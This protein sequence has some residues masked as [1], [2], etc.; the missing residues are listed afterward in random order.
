MHETLKKITVG[1]ADYENKT[2]QMDIGRC[3]WVAGVGLYGFCKAHKRT[4]DGEILKFLSN[5]V[6]INIDEA[7]KM[8]KINTAVLMYTVLYVYRQNGNERYLALCKKIADYFLYEAPKTRE[9]ALEH[10]VI[11]DAK[12]S[13]QIW[14]DTLFMAVIFLAEMGEY[15][16]K[17]A[18]FAAKQLCIHLESLY[19]NNTDL[20]FHAWN[21]I[22]KN[23][24]SG[25]RWGRANA[26]IIYSATEI[27]GILGDFEG[28]EVVKSYVKK[29]AA[30]LKELQTQNGAFRTVLNEESYEEASATAGVI[31]GI[32]QAVQLGIIE[33]EY[34]CVFDK[35]MEYLMSVIAENGEVNEVS[36]GTPV[37]KSSE[38]YK[39]IICVPTLY[40]QG[41]AAI[42][43]ALTDSHEKL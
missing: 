23:H 7:I 14:A 6:E 1:I 18:D 35:G 36:F 24:M 41:L 3:D 43:L 25:V 34:L 19:D 10:T 9:G 26:W 16:K 38:E 8:P 37:L 17:Y 27:I 32:K 20:Y 30:A 21:S 28:V 12:F 42:A 13:E 39:N 22:A 11:E 29:H 15:D 2:W 5:W 31:A 33:K 40:G 4:G